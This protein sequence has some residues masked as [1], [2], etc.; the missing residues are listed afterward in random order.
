MIKAGEQLLFS[1]IEDKGKTVVA[2][3]SMWAR[4]VTQPGECVPLVILGGIVV[5]SL[6]GKA[7]IYPFKLL[8]NMGMVGPFIFLQAATLVHPHFFYQI[9]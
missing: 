3:V 4:T 1:L 5:G 6:L 7:F 2:V 8:V 9:E